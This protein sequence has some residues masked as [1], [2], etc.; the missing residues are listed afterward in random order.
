VPL[1]CSASEL[2]FY[3]MKLKLHCYV[4]AQRRILFSFGK[5]FF[6]F[7]YSWSQGSKSGD[8]CV[9]FVGLFC[10]SLHCCCGV[11]VDVVEETASFFPL[12]L[13]LLSVVLPFSRR[14]TKSRNEHKE[15]KGK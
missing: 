15:N 4:F 10:L 7:K 11:G 1:L 9:G 2:C 13:F 3:G 6:S 12:N 14:T 5:A 8:R